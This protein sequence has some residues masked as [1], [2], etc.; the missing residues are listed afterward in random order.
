MNKNIII[1][2]LVSLFV[3]GLTGYFIAPDAPSV[4]LGVISVSTTATTTHG[5][6][7]QS[8]LLYNWQFNAVE[9][10]RNIRA[11]VNGI[12]SSTSMNGGTLGV[13]GLST[14]T[15][16]T[17]ITGYTGVSVGDFVVWGESTSTASVS[18]T[19]QVSAA[20]VVACYKINTDGSVAATLATSTIYATV[21]PR[22]TFGVSASIDVTTSSTPY[23]Q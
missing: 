8:S 10:L 16:S 14:S 15:A 2:V 21:L 22:S 13:A 3:G 17:T 4:P 1:A 9:S 12:T 19:C 11:E 7:L 20:N 23:N 5:T 6:A 18:L